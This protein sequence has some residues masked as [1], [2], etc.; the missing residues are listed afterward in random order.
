MTSALAATPNPHSSICNGVDAITRFIVPYPT[1][2]AITAVRNVGRAMIG[3]ERDRNARSRRRRR[4]R[5]ERQQHHGQDRQQ[6]QVQI[7]RQEWMRR[8]EIEGAL[9]HLRPDDRRQHAARQHQRDRARPCLAGR[10]P[11]RRRSAD[12]ARCRSPSRR[13]TRRTRTA[14]NCRCRCPA[15][16]SCCR[17]SRCAPPIQNP[18]LPPERANTMPAGI[19]AHIT[20]ICWIA[21]GSVFRPV[22]P[23]SL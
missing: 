23:T 5:R 13:E 11:R 10:Q 3:P 18:A 6:R 2:D 15:Q 4:Q 12:A 1:S 14:E 20:P 9:D 17:R 16:R 8:N 7:G 21:I 22:V 19:E